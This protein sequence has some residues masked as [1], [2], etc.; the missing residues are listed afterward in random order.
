MVYDAI[1]VGAGPAGSALAVRLARSGREVLL[2][3]RGRF[4]RDKVC[5]DLVSAKALQ[6][7]DDL[8]CLGR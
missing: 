6:L 7:L 1:I 5:G 4:P 3:E 8:G 2:L